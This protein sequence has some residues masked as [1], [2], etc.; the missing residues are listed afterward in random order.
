MDS[1]V[2]LLGYLVLSQAIMGNFCLSWN[3]LGYIGLLSQAVLGFL[4][5]L[6]LSRATFGYLGLSRTI[7]DYLELSYEIYDNL[8]LCLRPS[9]FILGYVGL[10]WTMAMFI[11]HGLPLAIHLQVNQV[12]AILKLFHPPFFHMSES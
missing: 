7:S 2:A 5:Y 11:Y 3:V 12:Y 10:S 6:E 1:K 9:H 4:G 8:W